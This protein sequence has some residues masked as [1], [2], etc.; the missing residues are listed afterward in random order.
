MSDQEQSSPQPLLKQPRLLREAGGPSSLL[1]RTIHSKII[2]PYLFLTMLVAILG[3]FVVTTLVVGTTK[4]R[5]VNQLVEAG[6]VAG[7]GVV[8]HENQHLEVLRPMTFTEGVDRALEAGNREQLHLLLAGLTSNADLDSMIVVDRAGRIVLRLDAD[9]SVSG[10]PV[11]RSGYGEDI[12]GWP[13][14]ALVLA[15]QVDERGDKYAG[16][17]MAPGGLVMF[18]TSA[19]VHNTDGELVGAIL[20]GSM[21]DRVITNLK[22]ESLADIV[23]YRVDGT[24]V[25]STIAEWQDPSQREALHVPPER[26]QQVVE[27]PNDPIVLEI[28]LFRRPYGMTFVPMIVRG[29]SIGMIGVLLPSNFLIQAAAVGRRT[30]TLIFAISTA[31]V[32]GIGY[33][34]AQRIAGPV[35]RLSEITRAM[36][37]GDLSQRLLNAPNDEI[38]DL[39]H[40][41][42][43]MSEELQRHTIALEA[44]A[45][46]VQAIL[47]S[48]ADGV[49]VCDMDG[50]II[51]RNQAARDLV[52]KRDYLE[53]KLLRV[54]RR[55]EET[56]FGSVAQRVDLGKQVVSVRVAP[57]RIEEDE[58]LG[59]VLVL[60]D[61]TREVAAER[62]KD[63][64]FN[65]IS[66]ELRTPL[67]AIKGYS[68]ILLHG[69]DRLGEER[70]Q[71]AIQ[72]IFEQT[73]TLERMIRQLIDLSEME[74]GSLYLQR[75][76]VQVDELV[77]KALDDWKPRFEEAD[78][79]AH[80]HNHAPGVV[81]N[82]DARRLR[83]ALDALLDNVCR[84]TPDGGS[85]E[86]SLEYQDD[87]AVLQVRDTGVGILPQD[88]PHVFS[89]FYRGTPICSDG[90]ELDVRGTG[91]GLYIVKSV[92]EAHGGRVWVTSEVGKGSTFSILL[93]LAGR[94]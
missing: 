15:E 53:E 62:L 37:A 13:I 54:L 65:S 18:Y 92:A 74:L 6:R 49:I 88:L 61:V 93:P 73:L 7:D 90:H 69:G 48:I 9:R 4:E 85:V 10:A 39:A 43:R 71:R 2:V 72:A 52:G 47:S 8:R 67:G 82:A 26:Y 46:R 57:V 30:L 34:V 51:M 70:E 14:V 40:S 45:A 58:Q 33:W 91:Q 27:Q 64:F 38:G 35:R 80:Y 21:L 1:I 20:V 42:N 63:N 22:A 32:I 78:L 41:F 60:R 55:R 50:R 83:W 17:V 19:P 77:A 44:E 76:P 87:V 3:T 5:F 59:E 79:V 81:M 68:D 12:S 75:A 23:V 84:Y 94:A 29:R 28:E 66:H 56:P 31:L 36:M 11:Y 89:R 24:P 86:V 16:L 25:A